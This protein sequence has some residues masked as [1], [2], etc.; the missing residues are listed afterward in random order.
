MEPDNSRGFLDTAAS[1]AQ[2]AAD[3]VRTVGRAV[4]GNYIGA[5]AAAVQS[6]FFRK[7]IACICAFFLFLIIVICSLPSILWNALVGGG[8]NENMEAQLRILNMASQINAV[9]LDDYNIELRELKKLEVSEESITTN[10]PIPPI[11]P[12]KIMAYYS[13]VSLNPD[14]N[15]SAIEDL[16]DT[17]DMPEV[18]TGGIRIGTSPLTDSVER[19]RSSVESAAELYG[20]SGYCD[21]LMAIMQQESGGRGNDVMQAAGS[22]YVYGTV[23]PESSIDGGVHYFAECLKKAGC[24]DPQD[25][26]HL[27]VAVQSYN[28]GMGYATWLKK[29]GYTGWT[30]TNAAEYSSYMLKKYQA[31]GQNISRYGDK[32]YIQHVFRYYNKSGST[33]S[34]V[35][36]IDIVHL[37]SVLRDYEGEYYYHECSGEEYE[38]IFITHDEPDFF[39]DTVFHLT[40]QQIETAKS[41]ESIFEQLGNTDFVSSNNILGSQSSLDSL[42]LTNAQ[43]TKYLA[44]AT[45]TDPNIS[46]A[47]SQVLTVGLSL[48]GKVG[49][50]WGGKYNGTGWNDN[51]GKNTL[52]T[53]SGDRTTGTYQPFGLDCSGFVDWA[54]RTAGVSSILQAGGTWHQYNA[55][56]PISSAQLRP[57]DLGFMLNSSDRT[58][59]VGIYVGMNSSGKRL[60]VHSQGGTGVCVSTCGFSQFRRVVD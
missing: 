3:A 9:F 48:V 25:W 18:I 26:A 27:E 51:W 14:E 49:Y 37:L 40:D 43:I 29:N 55:T 16:E 33:G 45:T 13:A 35:D 15:N 23:T 46:P 56:T 12:Y 57:G 34:M 60:W 58:T 17:N 32:Q 2:T 31:N 19:Y 41:Y 22:G 30:A 39:V 8:F 6:P 24:N 7:L 11:S 54:Y 44:I 21:M 10:E 36:K 28:Y 47:R 50:F 38:V 53:A 1:V 20:I 42:P 4:S 52:V 5:A 59:H